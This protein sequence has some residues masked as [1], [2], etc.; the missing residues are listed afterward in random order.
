VGATPQQSASGPQRTHFGNRNP[1][2]TSP[3]RQ[4]EMAAL[5]RCRKGGARSP[6]Q[7]ILR[8]PAAAAARRAG[9]R[10]RAGASAAASAALLLPPP[11]RSMLLL[12]LLL[13]LL[14][15]LLP[16]VV[17][18]CRSRHFVAGYEPEQQPA[19]WR[20]ICFKLQQA[21]H[22]YAEQQLLPLRSQ[23]DNSTSPKTSLAQ[24]VQKLRKQIFKRLLEVIFTPASYTYAAEEDGHAPTIDCVPL[25]ERGH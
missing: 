3:P 2:P 1:A 17:A 10:R 4:L 9:Q 14:L 24:S 11:L 8:R 22:P 25:L 15:R 21:R 6:W 23:P 16:Q 20:R 12:L 5:G 18:L 19:L 13:L 7:R